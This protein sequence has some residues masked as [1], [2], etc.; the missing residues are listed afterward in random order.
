MLEKGDCMDCLVA[1]KGVNIRSH[2]NLYEFEIMHE[3]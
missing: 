3:L 1:H 2:A